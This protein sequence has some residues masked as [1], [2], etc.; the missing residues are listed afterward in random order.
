MTKNQIL[1]D[2]ENDQ[3]KTLVGNNVKPGTAFVRAESNKPLVTLT[4][5][6][7]LQW[8]ETFG[9][10]T[11][12]GSSGRKITVT[13]HGGGVGLKD[14]E[15]TTTTSGSFHFPVTGA[16]ASS[17]TNGK[18]VYAVVGTAVAGTGVVPVTSLTLTKGTNTYFGFVEWFRGEDGATDTVVTI[19]N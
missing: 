3:H 17:A 15:A 18:P 13:R 5:S 7:D 8:S 12:Y 2:N 16:T 19:G 9:P 1:A 4:G 10:T 6:G 11:G 14:N